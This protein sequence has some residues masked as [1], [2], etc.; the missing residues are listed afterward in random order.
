MEEICWSLWVARASNEFLSFVG[1]NW[2]SQWPTRSSLIVDVWWA[3]GLG[4]K[5]SAVLDMAIEV[6]L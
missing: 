6:A 3:S 1:K 4:S 5:P 2:P